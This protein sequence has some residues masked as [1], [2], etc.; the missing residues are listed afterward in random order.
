[1]NKLPILLCSPYPEKL[2]V[3][4][5]EKLGKILRYAND[6]YVRILVPVVGSQSG[7]LV[8]SSPKQAVLDHHKNY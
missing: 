3:S 7:V 1:M 2:C 4:E 5:D 6:G 8:F